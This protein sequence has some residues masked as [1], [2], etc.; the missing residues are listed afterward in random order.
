VP[1]DRTLLTHG[2]YATD[3]PVYCREITLRVPALLRPLFGKPAALDPVRLDRL[4][5]EVRR[6]QLA[7]QRCDHARLNRGQPNRAP[8]VAS[9]LVF[10]CR[11]SNAVTTDDDH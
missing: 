5:D 2:N 1:V 6:Q 11:A 3:F 10:V 9:A 7:L 8:I 4:R